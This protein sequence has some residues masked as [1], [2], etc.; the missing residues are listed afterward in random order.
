MEG[1]LTCEKVNA[2]YSKTPLLT[3]FF[4]S[5]IR[6]WRISKLTKPLDFSSQFLL[7]QHHFCS[8]HNFPFLPDILSS[9]AYHDNALSSL[10]TF[11]F[12]SVDFLH[13]HLILSLSHLY[14]CFS[15]GSQLYHQPKLSFTFLYLNAKDA[16]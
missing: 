5:L 13:G 8:S 11:F 4:H 9:L 12:S 3:Q 14:S 16:Y 7:E 1:K 10:L 6:P 2:L 15:S